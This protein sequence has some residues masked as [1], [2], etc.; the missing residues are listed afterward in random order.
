M[1]NNEEGFWD[2]KRINA[3]IKLG[4]WII[5]IVVM[6]I[7][8]SITNKNNSLKTD[9]KGTDETEVKEKFDTFDSMRDKLLASNYDYS[10]S[11]TNEAT[12]TLFSGTKCNDE[13][14]GYKEDTSGI[15]K[16]VIKDDI[17][18]K[19]NLGDMEVITNLYEGLKEEYLNIKLLFK[20]LKPYIYNVKKDN[21]KRTVIY[22]KNE[23]QVKVITNLENIESIEIT[24]ENT[25]YV[26]NFMK[27]N[28]CQNN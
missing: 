7:V 22:Q 15:L 23:Y 21:D 2:E 4:L 10:F 27:T 8:F 12:K 11:I 24:D 26:L 20:N 14:S 19:N 5:F 25:I 1:K 17:V 6:L 13:I 28:K 16:Y 9:K 18:Y 3:C